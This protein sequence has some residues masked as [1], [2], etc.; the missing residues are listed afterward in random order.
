MKKKKLSILLLII[1]AICFAGMAAYPIQYFWQ[2]DSNEGDMEALREMRRSALVDSVDPT[3][4]VMAAEQTPSATESTGHATTQPTM[5]PTDAPATA[6]LTSEPTEGSRDEAATA[7]PS[8]TAAAS[9]VRASEA[10]TENPEVNEP[11]DAVKTEQPASTD[12][13]E[14]TEQPASTEQPTATVQ[15]QATPESTAAPENTDSPGSEEEQPA[16]I[17][18]YYRESSILP[19]TAKERVQLD[20]DN[21]LPAFREVY[22]QNNDLIGWLTIADT[23]VDYPVL[24]SEESD[25]YLDRDFYGEPNSNGQLILDS[26]CD[27]W[28]PS[29]NLIISGHNM[30][31]GAMFGRLAD[32]ASKSYWADHKLITFDTLLREGDYVVI[33]A[34]YSADYDVDEEGFRYNADIKYELDAELWLADV[35][36][37]CIYNT[38]IDAGF[39]DEFLTLTTCLYQREN[40]RFV[41]VARRVREGEVIE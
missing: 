14:S 41:V 28:T 26:G 12:H 1:M 27:P 16:E 8:A 22:E 15:P 21:I 30:K 35:F 23:P 19:Y 25:Y 4:T 33:A 40:G 31:S 13:P 24:Q 34:F 10:P 3:Q 6:E 37:N 32:Y 29:Y 9:A 18:R 38:G 36:E 39:G 17:D 7:I 20:E 11:T 2:K 5:E